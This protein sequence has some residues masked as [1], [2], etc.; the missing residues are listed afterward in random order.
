M[1]S[2]WLHISPAHIDDVRLAVLP[3]ASLLPPPAR[4]RDAANP[5]E[6]FERWGGGR[7]KGPAELPGAFLP[8]SSVAKLRVE[9]ADRV[10]P[11]RLPKQKKLCVTFARYRQ[12]EANGRIQGSDSRRAG[13][14][15]SCVKELPTHRSM[16]G[17]PQCAQP[18]SEKWTFW[19]H[20]FG[21]CWRLPTKKKNN[22]T[23]TLYWGGFWRP[24]T[25]DRLSSA[26]FCW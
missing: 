1:S 18:D 7:R 25:W 23:K 15:S 11:A 22:E 3:W 5:E 6:P 17:P 20:L 19:W 13:A 8:A 10:H 26:F 2:M 14:A 9:V 12:G 24:P 16:S 4:R 21:D